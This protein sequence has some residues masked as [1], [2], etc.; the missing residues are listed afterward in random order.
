MEKDIMIISSSGILNGAARCHS[1]V[2]FETP[3]PR[4]M[5]MEEHK[6]NSPDFV[7]LSQKE[8]EEKKAK[9]PLL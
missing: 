2:S 8:E 1:L 6:I 9:T 5:L 7:P 3:R 4:K